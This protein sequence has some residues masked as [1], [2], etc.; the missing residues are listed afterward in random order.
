MASYLFSTLANAQVVGFDPRVDQLTFSGL[1]LSAAD[2]SLTPSVSGRATVVSAPG[3]SITLD[4]LVPGLFRGDTFVFDDGS[5][6]LLPRVANKGLLTGTTG[7]DLLLGAGP[8]TALTLVSGDAAGGRADASISHAAAVSG[9]GRY[10]VFDTTATDLVAGDTNSLQ[11]LFLRDTATGT[12]TRVSVDGAGLQLPAATGEASLSL[13]GNVVAFT[14]EAGSGLAGTSLNSQA[15]VRNLSTGELTLVSSAADGTQANAAARVEAISGNG[16]YVAFSTA[17]DN[18][19]SGDTNG[20]VDLFVKDLQTGGV[21]RASTLNDFSTG[22]LFVVQGFGP[23]DRAFLSDDGRYAVFTT[24]AVNMV[25]GAL[26]PQAPNNYAVMLKDLQTGDLSVVSVGNDGNMGPFYDSRAEAVSGDGRF[27]LFSTADSLV[28][29]D[30]N[31]AADLYLRDTLAGTTVLVSSNAAGECL[32]N[33]VSLLDYSYNA[34]RSADMSA[35]GRYVVFSSSSSNVGVGTNNT[36]L[37]VVY[38]KDLV[39]GQVAMISKTAAGEMASGSAPTISADGNLITFN[40][41]GL[42]GAD[43]LTGQTGQPVQAWVVSNPLLTVEMRG[44]SGSDTYVVSSTRDQVVELAMDGTGIDTVRASI[45]YTLGD[46][47]EKLAL[48]GTALS[49]AGNALR[50]TLTGNAQANLLDGGAGA[51]TLTGGAGNDVYV[52]DNIGDRV[53]EVAG[54]GKDTVRSSVTFSLLDTDGAGAA[55]GGVEN[56]VLSGSAAINGTGNA[57]ANQITG[58]AVANILDGRAGA[59]T[60]SGGDGN[61]T[62]VVDNAGDRVLE[63]ATAGA[64]IDTVNST[65]AAYTL[66]ANVENGRIL[67]AGTASIAGN[68]LD[69]VFFAGAGDNLFDGGAGKDTVSWAD[70]SA[71]VNIN[72]GYTLGALPS[73]G[74]GSETLVSIENLIGSA[75]ADSLAGNTLAN[76]LDGG[77]GADFLVG[78]SGSDT[79]F[80]DNTGDVVSEEQGLIGDVDTVNVSGIAGYTLPDFVENGRVITSGATN[81]AGNAA[82]NLLVAGA[83]ANVLDGVSGNDTVSFAFAA[84]GVT[85]SLLAGTASGGSGLDTLLN[86]DNLTGSAF[87]DSLT[88]NG[89]SN[90]LDGGAGVDTLA[91]GAGDDTYVVDRTGDIVAEAASGGTDTVFSSATFSLLDT[92]GAGTQGGNIENLVLTGTAAINGSG[93]GLRNRVTGNAAVN[94]LNGGAGAD[95]LEGGAGDDTYIVD[96]VGDLTIESASGGRDTVVS[97]ASNWT[98]GAN[99][100]NG[101]IDVQ[102]AANL[103]GNGLNNLLVAGAGDNVLDGGV[104]IDTVSYETASAGV[105]ASLLLATAQATVGSGSDTLLNVENLSGSAFA[106]VL[107]GKAGA[108]TLDGGSGAD[109]LAGGAG[110]DTYVLDDAGDVVQEAVGGGIDTLVLN[111]LPSYTLGDNIENARIVSASFVSIAGND[112]D[113]LVIVGAGSARV[114]AKAGVDTVSFAASTVAVRMTSSAVGEGYVFAGVTNYSFSGVENVIGSAFDDTLAGSAGNNT[115]DGGAGSD[116]VDY[117]G[118]SRTPGASGINVNLGLGSETDALGSDT[119]VDIQNVVGTDFADVIVGNGDANLIRGGKGADTLSGGG[120]ADVFEFGYYRFG[121]GPAPAPDAVVVTDFQSGTDRVAIRAGF[122]GF[123]LGDAD[124]LLEGGVSIAGPGGF[125]PSAELVVLTTNLATLGA[126]AAAAAIGSANTAY[127]AGRTALFAVDNGASSQLYLFTS[128]GA[129]AV[130][131]AAELQLLV[132]L[133]GTPA[134]AVSDYFFMT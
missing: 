46:N 31:V 20:E 76:V 109:T 96:N 56:L 65:L 25:R 68:A 129:D 79:Y 9:E 124:D 26:S 121:P 43:L 115:L 61:D 39:T 132:T 32:D 111:A 105:T 91:G 103:N 53:R 34:L 108:N 116:T 100:E 17:A 74:S 12:T 87:A 35:D 133:E 55:G 2:I 29:A 54:G 83:G 16:R 13:D 8:A 73:G 28:S 123:L 50:N 126:S 60:L 92:D 101:R 40:G 41:Y 22:A 88:G 6:V 38:V 48:T 23:S 64:G 125:D 7:D 4:N 19:V 94:V 21:V 70:A 27:V 85:A 107:T 59:D 97:R 62:Y 102:T 58:N 37:D 49:G 14:V 52:V 57:F 86:I 24:G 84:T 51:D 1:S 67:S 72:I 69:N 127:T 82:D 98:L 110:N 117:S 118:L 93:N 45:D 5:R 112:L 63:A 134:T 131:S 80:V 42:Y 18:V 95:T 10:I 11:D 114:D 104:G 122:T 120:A 44:G 113:N 75:F 130:V 36:L 3:K 89:T 30:T 78:R 99:I 66:A 47:I 33:G 81:L 128:S 71:G 90:V 15:Y 106:D 77:S 119:L